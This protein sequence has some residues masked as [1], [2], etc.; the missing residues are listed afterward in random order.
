MMVLIAIPHA[1]IILPRNDGAGKHTHKELLITLQLLRSDSHAAERNPSTA[2]KGKRTT[3]TVAWRLV[4]Y[5][6]ASAPVSS[7]RLSRS[8]APPMSSARFMTI[9][10]LC[11]MALL[12]TQPESVAAIVEITSDRP[13]PIPGSVPS[14]PFDD[15]DDDSEEPQSRNRQSWEK[16]WTILSQ[17]S[18]VATVDE[19]QELQVD[20]PGRVFISTAQS[21][22]PLGRVRFSGDSPDVLDFF[23]VASNG[24]GAI[25]IRQ[26]Q[27]IKMPSF[28][29]YLLVEVTL[30]HQHKLQSLTSTASADVVVEPNV[31]ISE[32]PKDSVAITLKG[33][34][35]VFVHDTPTLNVQDIVLVLVGSG[36]IELSTTQIE[37]TEVV[38]TLAG[39]GDI[40]LVTGSVLAKKTTLVV[41]GSGSIYVNSNDFNSDEVHSVVAGS[42]DISVYP[43][44]NCVRE[45]VT[46]AG[47]GDVYV[48]SIACEDAVVKIGGSGDAIVKVSHSL[49]GG[50]VGSGDVKY[51]GS[52][53]QVVAPKSTLF[54][55]SKSVKPMAT[56]TDD[57]KYHSVKISS[58]PERKPVHLSIN[59]NPLDTV[60]DRSVLVPLV[61][62]A[63][64]AAWFVH[65]ENKKQYAQTPTRQEMQP[66]ASTQAQ[67]Y[68]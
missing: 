34:G 46:I 24:K 42:G 30:S 55:G 39:S 11:G 63:L 6:P 14:T 52:A 64:L 4:L 7:P 57:N 35:S 41:G 58:L 36:D 13:T 26:R 59:T 12:S 61:F 21:Q 66:L 56:Q 16:T 22:A 2:R 44:G 9:A 19:I 37:A 15:D 32:A 3:S 51:F 31:L 1:A 10:F 49:S 54:S 68:V 60:T 29:G 45:D 67:V 50:V 28:D 33:S 5:L 20:V 25:E 18:L 38:S 40:R 62:V 53:P 23:E 48:G 27:G 8:L 17:T 43:A 65:H 47:S